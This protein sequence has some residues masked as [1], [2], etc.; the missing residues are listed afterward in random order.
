MST[1]K[2]NQGGGGKGKRPDQAAITT[3]LQTP[4]HGKSG[5][6]APADPISTTPM[7][8]PLAQID[9]YDNNPR[10]AANAMYDDIKASIEAN[11]LHQPLVITRRPGEANYMI[12]A[13]GNTRLAVVK[14]LYANNNDVRFA[15][16]NCVFEPWV[17]ESD[18]LTAHLIENDTRGDLIFIDRAIAVMK[19]K[20]MLEE[21]SG[22]TLSQRE[23]SKRLAELGYRLSHSLISQMAYALD[24]LLPA[25]PMALN[26]G[27]GRPQIEK[28]RSLDKASRTVWLHHS[29]TDDDTGYEIL[30][31]GVLSDNDSDNWQYDA[32]RRQ[33][34]TM[35]AEALD[36]AL[37]AMKLDMATALAG[38]SLDDSAS[39]NRS[40]TTTTGDDGQRDAN[41]VD[42]VDDATSEGVNNTQTPADPA[43][44]DTHQPD[45]DLD[46]RSDDDDPTWPPVVDD[47]EDDIPLD[48]DDSLSGDTGSAPATVTTPLTPP[49]NTRDTGS[50]SVKPRPSVTS[51]KP[52]T[53]ELPPDLK[54]LRGRAYT[55]AAK[56]AQRHHISDLLDTSPSWGF[57]YLLKDILTRTPERTAMMQGGN[58]TAEYFTTVWVWWQLAACAEMTAGE[59]DAI[60]ERL[61]DGKLREALESANLGVLE[62]NGMIMEPGLQGL[63]LWAQ[64][65]PNSLQD[66]FDL[67]ATYRAMK[68]LIDTKGLDVWE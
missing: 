24:V 50:E 31:A 9:L 33:L 67:I 15:Q 36:Q 62:D 39:Q 3:M 34:E 59:I 12:R 46:G 25:M 17:S 60:A 68:D 61:P 14:D 16:V 41:T 21:E 6:L 53:A 38:K 30:W 43:T 56:I 8:L 37:H 64:L 23:L 47:D 18:T 52:L 4:H 42:W 13:G 2:D 26:T 27:M 20:Q 7:V 22:K 28:L 11:G 29:A 5:D 40:V 55:L 45:N 1:D 51:T 44:I 19:L 49:S 66:L 32:C 35:L 10:S 58:F 54:S 57:G 48:D 65:P 63:H